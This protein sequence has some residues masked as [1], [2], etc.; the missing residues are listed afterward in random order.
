MGPSCGHVG[1]S[2]QSGQQVLKVDLEPMRI[3][4]ISSLF[5]RVGW[6]PCLCFKL[7]DENGIGR[8]R[9]DVGVEDS[10]SLV[11]SL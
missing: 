4:F 6:E 8:R 2:M 10:Y 5:K 3:T 9:V 7:A 11:S 1:Y